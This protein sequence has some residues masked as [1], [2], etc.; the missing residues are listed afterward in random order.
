M[1][2]AVRPSTCAVATRKRAIRKRSPSG[3]STLRSFRWNGRFLSTLPSSIRC[4]PPFPA[5]AGR[6]ISSHSR[7]RPVGPPRM[8]CTCRISAC[9][10]VIAFYFIM[11]LCHYFNI[12]LVRKNSSSVTWFILHI[13][14]HTAAVYT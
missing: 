9:L 6:I 3:C 11:S 10:Y 14:S 8:W 13:R 4:L 5:L 2:H 7:P 1:S 12:S